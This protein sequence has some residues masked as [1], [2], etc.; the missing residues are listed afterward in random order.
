MKRY[1]EEVHRFI[2]ANVKGTA[3]RDLAQ[4][5][6]QRFGTAFTE[7]SMNAYKKNHKL[8]SGTKGGNPKGYSKVY[9]AEVQE[10]IKEN[11]QRKES[12]KALAEAVNE[13]FGTAYTYSQ[14]KAYLKRHGILTGRTG[15]FEK[16]HV[17]ANKGT[18]NGGWEPTQFKKGNMPVN[19]KPVGTESVRKGHKERGES[20]RIWVKVAEPNQWRMKSVIVWE[21]HY[22]PVP[23]GKI[24]IFLDGDTMNTDISNLALIDKNTNVRLNQ[25]GLRTQSR[26]YTL[27]AISVAELV[28]KTAEAKKGKRHG[29]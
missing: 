20:P 8:K 21:S 7:A 11:A 22:G 10:Y 29:K 18:H 3:T 13:R 28:I 9:P 14:V 2:E 19:H 5:V 26:E 25:L 27:A 12:V 15:R 1:P 16:G 23:K 17:P 6:N 4:M 24:V